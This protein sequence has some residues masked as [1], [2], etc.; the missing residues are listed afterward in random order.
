MRARDVMTTRVITVAPDARVPEVAQLLLKHR[1]SAV[2]VVGPDGEVVGIV[3]EGDLIR[4]AETG[5]ERHRSWW[6]TLMEG[7]EDLAREYVKAHGMQASDVMSPDVVFVH[8]DTPV[9]E[10]ASLLERRRIKRVPV[11]EDGRLVGIVSRADLLRGLAAT[12][13]PGPAPSGDDRTIRQQVLEALGSAPWA[14]FGATNVIVTDG[15]VH[16]WGW[17]SSADERQAMVVL[18]RGVPGVRG[19]EEHLADMPPLGV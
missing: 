15:I 4:R 17:V 12:P 7:S 6:L 14:T 11:V 9:S 10:I 8:R 19:V 16:L 2:P 3:S 13:A 18:A 1:I 5:G